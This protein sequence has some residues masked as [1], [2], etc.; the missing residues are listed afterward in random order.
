MCVWGWGGSGRTKALTIPPLELY[1]LH[2]LTGL[3]CWK[4]ALTCFCSRS[5]LILACVCWR[6]WA[7]GTGVGAWDLMAA[8]TSCC[9]AAW[10]F[11]RATEIS[12]RTTPCTLCITSC[13]SLQLQRK[14]EKHQLHCV[15]HF[16]AFYSG[17]S[18]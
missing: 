4:A 14:Q 5:C 12:S 17:T 3:T 7:G 8:I 1:L 15:M 11:S 13:F 18:L 16:Y 10:C 6:S 9:M 2:Q